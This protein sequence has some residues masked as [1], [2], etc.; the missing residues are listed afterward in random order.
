VPQ[1]REKLR[2]GVITE[3]MIDVLEQENTVSALSAS[4]RH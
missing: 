1:I 4:R 3:K 2:S